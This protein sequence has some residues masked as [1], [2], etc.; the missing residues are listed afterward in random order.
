MRRWARL[1]IVANF[2]FVGAWLLAAT[3]QGPAYSVAAHT[4]SDMYA[5]GAPGAWFLVLTFTL[6]GVAVL[7]FAFR[8]LWPALRAAGRPARVGTILLGLSIF[9]LGDLLSVFEQQGCRL[10]DA[11]CT[12][13]A[14]TATFGGAADATLSTVGAFA[15]PVCGF[16]LAAAMRRLPEWRSWTRPTCYAAVALL[17]LLV[18]DGILA[19]VDLGG[20]GERLFALG[21]AA[22]ITVLAVGVLRRTGIVARTAV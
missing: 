17:A 7:L 10:A 22:W 15:L 21:G 20:F 8:S 14:Q 6:C 11:G 18:L 13:D 12:P 2:V 19:G 16:F 4:I 1:V 5:D 9:G 3:W